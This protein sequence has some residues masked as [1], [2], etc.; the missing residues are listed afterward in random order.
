MARQVSSWRRAVAALA[1][2]GL[3]LAGCTTQAQRIGAD[4]GSDACYS[5]RKALDSTG[6]YF[7]EDMLKG[8]AVGAI[9]GALAGGLIGGDWKGALIGAAVGA[10]VGA[11]A[12]YWQHQQQQAKDQAVLYNSVLSDLQRENAE[13]DKTQLAFDQLVQCRQ[14]QAK[15]VRADFK[16]GRLGREAAEVRLNTIKAQ[17][18]QDIEIAQTINQN[19]EKRSAN[20]DYA[21]QQV[22]PNSS[23]RVQQLAQQQSRYH[24]SSGGKPAKPAKPSKPSQTSGG[25]PQE[26]ILTQTATNQAKRDDYK[27]SIEAAQAQ[28]GQG[29]NLSWTL[30]RNAA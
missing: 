8:A 25:K 16:A 29:F 9:G 7:A 19:I 15:L 12:G 13:L 1:I 14:N 28:A 3:V 27:Q 2:G 20:F 6:D 10:A 24:G 23:A 5:Y 11:A 18:L 21:N 26:Q 22:N 30:Q 4:D 17:Y